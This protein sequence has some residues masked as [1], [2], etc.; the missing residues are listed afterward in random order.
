MGIDLRT[1]TQ[2]ITE[3]VA[4]LFDY[5]PQEALRGIESPLCAFREDDSEDFTTKV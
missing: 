1:L 5:G 2:K 4:D 3:D